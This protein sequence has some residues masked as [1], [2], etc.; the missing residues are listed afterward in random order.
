MDL[1]EK[2]RARPIP[3]NNGWRSAVNLKT[4]TFFKEK[5]MNSRTLTII[6]TVLM[7]AVC[8][9]QGQCLDCSGGVKTGGEISIQSLIVPTV[10]LSEVYRESIVGDYVAAG[11][12]LRSSASGN[13]NISIPAGV[14]ILNA[15]LYWSIM[16]DSETP[17]AVLADVTFNGNAVTG[18]KIGTAGDPCSGRF[19]RSVSGGCD[20]R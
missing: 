7:L 16:E 1:I 8:Q 18:I 12:G 19:L 11:V 15:F 9:A 4:K 14:T 17:S 10:P 13:I 20:A 2:Q 5:K 6:A 3:T